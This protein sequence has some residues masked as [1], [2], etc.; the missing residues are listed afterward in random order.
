MINLLPISGIKKTIS[1][2]R[3]RLVTTALV[4]LAATVLIATVLL[5]PAYLLASHKR[6]TV[7]DDL[8]KA[9]DQN[10]SSQDAKDLEKVIKETNAILDLLGTKGEK[11]S[12]SSDILTKTAGFRTENI[13]LTGIFYDRNDLTRSLSL[14]GSA[15]SRQSLSG[16]I[17]TLKKDAAFEDVSLPISDL[18]KDRNID[19][20]I[21]IKLKGSKQ[22]QKTPP[23][24]NE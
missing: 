9:S 19:F 24:N 16:F 11:F 10:I 13:K 15:A 2:Y 7:L 14:K 4:M 1:E 5:F 8:S 17:E 22:E 6:T 23:Q 3:I 18:V 20:T 12:I 21:M